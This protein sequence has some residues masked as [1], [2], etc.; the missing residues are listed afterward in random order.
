MKKIIIKKKTPKK[1][2][3]KIR[4]ESVSNFFLGFKRIKGS[5]NQ[6]FKINEET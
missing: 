6:L 1:K 4:L 2:V 5:Y 3:N